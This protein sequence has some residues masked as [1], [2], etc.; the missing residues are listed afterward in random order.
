[1]EERW[2]PISRNLNSPGSKNLDRRLRRLQKVPA[3]APQDQLMTQ[4]TLRL[5]VL[6]A[7]DMDDWWEDD[8]SLH[9]STHPFLYPSLS[10][11]LAEVSLSVLLL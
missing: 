3:A 6:S 2:S 1:M 11:S 4:Q 9:L 8:P 5:S 7:A 10:P